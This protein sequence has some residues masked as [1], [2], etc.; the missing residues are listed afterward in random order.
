MKIIRSLNQIETKLEPL[1]LTIG[2]FDGVHLGHRAII[3]KLGE[4]AQAQNLKRALLT[5]EPHP[6]LF[7]NQTAPK[8]FLI[9]DLSEKIRRLNSA[10]DYLIILPF[11]K[12]LA[13][14][15]AADFV[16]KI[17]INKLNAKHI[18]IGH[19]FVFGKNRSGNFALLE[20]EAKRHQFELTQVSAVTLGDTICSSSSIRRLIRDGKI[21]E[22]NK[23]LGENFAVEGK[24]IKG[25]GVGKE[26][27]CKTANIQPQSLVIKPKLGVYRALTLIEKSAKKFPSAVNFGISPTFVTD[28][29]ALYESHLLSFNEDLLGKTIRIELVDFLRDEKKFDSIDEL[30]QWIKTDI[31]ATQQ[32]FESSGKI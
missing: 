9:T 19:D 16:E 24:V 32:F 23:L 11:D 4:I 21:A 15:S 10:F 3:K 31:L 26:L 7:F 28:G 13:E 5:F 14:L 20:S 12:N 6:Y 22:A 8:D 30:K 1:A 25:R 29:I 27:N 17:L 18:V 2:N